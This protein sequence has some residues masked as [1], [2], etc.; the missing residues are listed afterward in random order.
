MRGH[1]L[2]APPVGDARGTGSCRSPARSQGCLSV[3][4]ARSAVRDRGQH[5]RPPQSSRTCR[6]LTGSIVGDLLGCFAFFLP[7]F[8]LLGPDLPKQP[9]AG[10][11][12]HYFLLCT[13]SW[14]AAPSKVPERS[15]LTQ[16]F[17]GEGKACALRW[18]KQCACF[19]GI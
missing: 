1:L 8:M 11:R 7:V 6:F 12:K 14:K 5:G 16:H 2:R 19:T 4:R 9:R 13:A 3:P 18:D 10:A 15:V 17:T